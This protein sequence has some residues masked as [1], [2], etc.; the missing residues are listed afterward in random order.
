MGC[1]LLER[2]PTLQQLQYAHPGNTA[3]VLPRTQLPFAESFFPRDLRGKNQKRVLFKT[4]REKQ[5]RG[6]RHVFFWI[7]LKATV[8]ETL[9]GDFIAQ[10][11]AGRWPTRDPRA[12]SASITGMKS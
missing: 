12:A 11:D 7:V 6:E 3:Q 10:V 4:D 1:D 2:W 5:C 9:L 8:S